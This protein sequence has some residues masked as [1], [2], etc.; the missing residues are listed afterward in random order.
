[1]LGNAAFGCIGA[2]LSPVSSS[3]SGV[4]SLFSM[5]TSS[6]V[7]NISLESLGGS[8]ENCCISLCTLF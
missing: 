1:M 8:G 4:L 5:S 6:I 3:I 7:G 2:L